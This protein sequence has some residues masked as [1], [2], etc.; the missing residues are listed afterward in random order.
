MSVTNSVNGFSSHKK[1]G[2][3]NSVRL[4]HDKRASGHEKPADL[5]NT[6]LM[7]KKE[8]THRYNYLRKHNFSHNEVSQKTRAASSSL[9]RKDEEKYLFRPPT[10]GNNNMPTPKGKIASDASEKEDMEFTSKMKLG[11]ESESGSKSKF[12]SLHKIKRVNKIPTGKKEGVNNYNRSSSRGKQLSAKNRLVYKKD[13]M[14]NLNSNKNDSS[15]DL[16]HPPVSSKAEN[17]ENDF[18]QANTNFKLNRTSSG[19]DSHL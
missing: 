12:V 10:H 4:S 6:S 19:R 13:S 1:E 18:S 7:W 9:N 15:I 17:K 16:F 5:K 3:F 11:R 2:C 8:S 14:K